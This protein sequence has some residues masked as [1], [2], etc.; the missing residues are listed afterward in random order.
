MSPHASEQTGLPSSWFDDSVNQVDGF[1]RKKYP[2]PG[3]PRNYL[4]WEERSVNTTLSCKEPGCT[5]TALLK[6]P[7][8]PLMEVTKDCKLSIGFHPT[9]FDDGANGEEV[10]WIRVN[11]HTVSTKCQP[12]ASGCNY[13]SANTLLPCVDA[14]PVNRQPSWMEG[15]YKEYHEYQPTGLLPHSGLLNISAKI[16][17]VVDECAY[18]GNML[19]AVSMMTCLVAPKFMSLPGQAAPTPLSWSHGFW[20]REEKC[21][22]TMPLQC[23]SRGCAAEISMGMH[24]DC[25]KAANNCTLSIKV[26]QT[27]FDNSEGTREMIEYI[28][29]QGAEVATDLRPGQNPC[30]AKWRGTPLSPSSLTYDALVDYDVT[31]AVKRGTLI[32]EGKISKFVDECAS[33]GYMFDALATVT[34]STGAANPG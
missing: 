30:K 20:R 8:D 16:S 18:E 34:C 14:L 1:G 21:A 15:I 24:S 27:D 13:S 5:A 17:D 7:F 9:D 19:S 25:V 6:A 2:A 3:S 23:P 4:Y 28:K 11:D 26:N 33:N 29:V 12:Q 22:A 32:V 31:D 10:Q